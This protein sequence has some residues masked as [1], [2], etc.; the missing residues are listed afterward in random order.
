MKRTAV[1]L[2]FG[3]QR[4]FYGKLERARGEGGVG[5]FL[6]SHWVSS[7]GPVL[8]THA[9][10]KRFQQPWFLCARPHTFIGSDKYVYPS[11]AISRSPGLP[12]ARHVA[13]SLKYCFLWQE[14]RRPEFISVHLAP[15]LTHGGGGLAVTDRVFCEMRGRV[16]APNIVTSLL[17]RVEKS[18]PRLQFISRNKN[19]L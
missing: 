19:I 4:F 15:A 10:K 2:I 17:K 3:F 9:K 11:W 18:D 6:F 13:G 16:K 14:A 1:V 7:H 5:V 12:H 8:V